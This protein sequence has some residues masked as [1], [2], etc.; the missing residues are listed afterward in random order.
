MKTNELEKEIGLSKYTIRYYEKEGL[1][2]PKRE[3]NG[4]RDYDD[5]TVQKL[6]I[7]K[8]L[9]NLQISVDDIKAILDGELDFRHCLKINQVNMQKQIESMNE[10][11]DTIDDYYDKDLPLIEE[12]SEIKNNNNKMGLGFQKTTS[13]VSLGRKLTPELARRQLIITFIGALVVAVSFSRMPYDLGNMRVL[14]GIVFFI[15][16]FMLM[17]AFSFKQTSAMMLDNILNQSVEFLSDGIR[18][19]KFNNFID[20]VK[21][22][23]AVLLSKE[24]KFMKEYKYEDIQSVELILKHRYES[25]GTPIAKDWYVLDYRFEFKDGNHFYFYWPITLDDDARFIGTILDEK[26]ENVIDKDH[27]IDALKNGIHLNDYVKTTEN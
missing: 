25:Y 17:I 11:K 8:F 9:R 23:Y 1:I 4:Y 12:L 26:V 7:I 21:Y 27:V 16:T 2:Q 20:N 24:D 10:I 19:Y 22:F 14:V 6:K 13:T 5:E 18:Y 3:E 15:V